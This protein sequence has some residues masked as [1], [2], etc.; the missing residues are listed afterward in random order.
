MPSRTFSRNIST[1]GQPFL[2]QSNGGTSKG[3]LKD[4]IWQFDLNAAVNPGEILTNELSGFNYIAAEVRRNQLVCAYV[5]LHEYST[6]ADVQRYSDTTADSFGR[7]TPE[8][9]TIESGLPV[10]FNQA[11]NV[12]AVQFGAA[13]QGGDTLFIPATNESYVVLTTRSSDFPGLK[14][15]VVQRQDANLVMT[16]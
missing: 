9:L 10:I 12:A 6:T 11:K 13:V 15:L 4:G 16:A 1:H 7:T 14:N 2:N 8:R 5:R 3:V